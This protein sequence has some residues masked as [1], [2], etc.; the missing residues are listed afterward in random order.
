MIFTLTPV[1]QLLFPVSVLKYQL[2][3]ERLN[4]DHRSKVQVYGKAYDHR[5]GSGETCQKNDLHR[6]QQVRWLVVSQGKSVIT[7]R[8]Y[9]AREE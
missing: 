2:K 7:V 9:W 4:V 5:T 6:E 3:G 8:K 1:S